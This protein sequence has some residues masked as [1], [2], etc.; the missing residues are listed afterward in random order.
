VKRHLILVGL[1][2]SGKTAVGARAAALLG[3]TFTDLDVVLT[4]AAGRPI[5]A[6]FSEE[7][8]PAFRRLERAA[9]AGAL[10]AAP[11]LIAPGGGW[12][13]QPGNL[14]AAA[15]KGARVVYLRVTPEV[16]ATRLPADG[17]RP[18]LGPGNTSARLRELLE[19]R[20]PYY[21]RAE[22]T[23]DGSAP[24]EAVAEAVALV[25]RQ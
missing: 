2:G 6:L 20:E 4:Q 8:E 22:A 7:G 19:R 9:M 3:A 25:A 10:D 23:V 1:P 5:A 16:A 18:L 21:T 14:E 11:H 15:E 13:A 12:A 24:V 17:S